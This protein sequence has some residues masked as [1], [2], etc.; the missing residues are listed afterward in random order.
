[1][2]YY[3]N[4]ELWHLVNRGVE[5]RSIVMDD[6]DRVRF[7]H[8]LYALNDAKIVDH[9]SQPGRDSTQFE[10]KRDLLV[11]IHAYCLMRNHYHLLVSEVKD[12]GISKFMQKF[13]MGYTKYFNERHKR[14]AG[15]WQG[16]YRKVLVERES[17]FMY[18]PYY[19]H[20]NPLDYTMPEWRKGRVTSSVALLKNLSAYRWSSHLDYLGEKNFPSVIDKELLHETLGTRAQYERELTRVATNERLASGSTDFEID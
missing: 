17:H 7:I 1:M 3:I 14:T 5:K 13:N 8:D 4:M 10:A 9:I 20:L 6:K 19:I 18:V 12:R 15:L 11:R 16:K 2:R